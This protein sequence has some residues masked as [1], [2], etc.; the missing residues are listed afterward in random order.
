[1]ENRKFLRVKA[2][3]IQSSNVIPS[4]GHEQ[5]FLDSVR[6]SGVQQPL[7]VR[8]SLSNP[9]KYELIDGHGRLETVEPEQEGCVEVR[10][11]SDSEAF[12]IS[13]ATSKA[14]PKSTFESAEFYAAYV[15]AVKKETGEKGA[16]VRVAAETGL[17]ESEL[18]QYLA[19]NKLF[20]ELHKLDEEANFPML[21]TMGMNKLYKISELAGNPDLLRA[22]Q[23]IEEKER[24]V[25]SK[26][27]LH[28]PKVSLETINAIVDRFQPDPN[29]K[30]MQDILEDDKPTDV[31]SLQVGTD[32]ALETRFND[33]KGKITTMS[34]ESETF[35][36]NL[37]TEKVSTEESN[38]K[39]LEQMSVCFR[40]IVYY[41]KKLRMRG[42]ECQKTQ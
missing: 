14:T 18:S 24:E 17:S 41:G 40:R 11:D 38:L 13:D 19:I 29:E 1:M 16:L 30:I 34:K 21:K 5:R 8:P 22:A 15:A 42:E 10:T 7:I 35:V 36:E 25:E 39:V 26:P 33:L 23:E 4:R 27:Y 9:A 6:T 2:K 37:A 3:N 20:L 32:T 28:L 31:A 12:R